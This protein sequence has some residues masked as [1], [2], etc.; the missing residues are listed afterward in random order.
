MNRKMY[1]GIAALIIVLIAAG[2][3]MYWQWS[4][5]QQMKEQLAEDEPML[6][7]NEKG[8]HAVSKADEKPPDEPGF[9]WVRHGDHWD[10]V[11]LSEPNETPTVRP[12][13]P[14]KTYDGPLTFHEELLETNPV[15]ALRL[16]TEER[17]HWSAKWI[18]PF[19]PDDFEAASLARS[20]YLSEYY[21]SI[22]EGD[23]P[24][25]E[26]A[27]QKFMEIWNII[28]NYPWGA[29]KADLMK[30]GWPAVDYEV[31]K[32]Y[33]KKGVGK[34]SNFF[35]PFRDPHPLANTPANKVGNY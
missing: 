8:Q 35:L 29:R 28:N 16:Q 20:Q 5:V 15:E 23:S 19:P 12:T 32:H 17:G 2:G 21:I 13:P 22:G 3:F 9:E 1:W 24:A 25:H 6:E 7:E 11:P 30:L 18:P 10:K 26:K 4:T 31:L 27:S 34:P 33:D 14:P